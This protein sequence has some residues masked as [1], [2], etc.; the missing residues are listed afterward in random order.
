[1]KTSLIGKGR[2]LLIYYYS[3]CLC[4][5]IHVFNV[6]RQLKDMVCKTANAF[7]QL[8]IKKGDRVVL[9]MPMIPLAVAAMLA[10]TRIGAIHRYSV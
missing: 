4:M 7:K 9:Y 10:C 2:E 6:F 3:N 1:M 5:H 8:G